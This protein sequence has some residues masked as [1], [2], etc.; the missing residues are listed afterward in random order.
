MDDRNYDLEDIPSVMDIQ[1]Y[2]FEPPACSVSIKKIRR[3][4]AK[5]ASLTPRTTHVIDGMELH[6]F[7][8]FIFVF[9]AYYYLKTYN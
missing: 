5:K 6:V 8:K 2:M 3:K 9:C 4:V 7:G 1:P